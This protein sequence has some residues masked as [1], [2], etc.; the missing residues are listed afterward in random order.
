MTQEE[1][2][3][4]KLTHDIDALTALAGALGFTLR[5]KTN[6]DP[7]FTH[8]RAK[9]CSCGSAP[10]VCMSYYEPG[11][12]LTMCPRCAA[13]TVLTDNPVAAVR[14]WNHGEYSEGA[15]LMRDTLTAKNMS[16]LGAQ[17]LTEGLKR[18]AVRDLM[19]AE[20]HGGLD[21]IQAKHA[22]WFIHNPAVV[23]DIVSGNRRRRE[24]ELKKAGKLI[25]DDL[26]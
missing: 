2:A 5:Y 25:D 13:R 7:V 12:W 11:K 20:R 9:K 3:Q 4:R 10:E 18:Q 19:D 26:Y 24:Q 16:D 21:S 17:N 22:I 23:E 6:A 1:K 14:A 15:Q 8:D